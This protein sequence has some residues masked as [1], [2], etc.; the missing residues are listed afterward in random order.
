LTA[1]PQL[2]SIRSRGFEVLFLTD[3]VDPFA[4]SNLQEFE[5]KKL[6]DVMAAEF[7]LPNAPEKTS[8]Q[9][10]E[11]KASEPLM[12]KIQDVLGGRVGE[13]RVSKRLADSPACLVVPS[14]GLPP[15]LERMLKARQM[16][17]P[18]VRRILEVNPEHSLIGQLRKMYMVEPNSPKLV[19]W[20]ELMYDQALLSEGSPVEDPARFA[21]RLTQLMSDAASAALGA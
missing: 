20:I 8:S 5:G 9:E 18:E 4:I 14:G 13:V 3:P 11:A 2:E 17:V 6:V 21:R 7:Q 16:D 12:K 19:D 1:S 10:E 15:Y